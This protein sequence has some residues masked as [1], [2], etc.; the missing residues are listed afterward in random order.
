MA[1]TLVAAGRDE[2]SWGRAWHVPSTA[3]I[4]TRELAV[5]LAEVTGAPAP[6]LEALSAAELAFAGKSDPVVAEVVEMLYMLERPFVVNSSAA[7][8]ALDLKP[9]PLDEVL[10]SYGG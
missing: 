2:R 1:R 4:S 8:R 10:A 9:T 6:D 7:E 3:T 5:R